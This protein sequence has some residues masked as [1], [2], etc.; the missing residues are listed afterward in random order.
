[1]KKFIR[2]CLKLALFFA[3]IGSAA[4]IAA[5]AMGLNWNQL[6]EMMIQKED[7]L[8]EENHQHDSLNNMDIEIGAGTVTIFYDN[9]DDI[10]VKQEGMRNYSCKADGDTLRISA[11]NKVFSN[12]S[13]G[14]I[15]IIV[16][17]GFV[18][19]EVDMEIGAGQADV[20]DL[21][22]EE[23]DI[24]VG[25]GQANL[26]NIDVQYLQAKTG[27]GEI[28]AELVGREA[29]YNY[30]VECGIGEIVI[31]DSSFS[32]LGR[33]ANIE[34]SGAHRELDVECSVGQIT[35]EFQETTLGGHHH[36]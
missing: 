28:Q 21:C 16:P 30:D 17:T 27:A 2:V 18:F 13:N 24:E 10:K 1:M 14:D 23:F 26:N 20:S 15:T 36:V 34:N 12:N 22:A 9:V 33:E 35:V 5:F 31:G 29:D 32:G 4:I 6:K 3:V 11:G 25:A 19:K 8:E 7:S